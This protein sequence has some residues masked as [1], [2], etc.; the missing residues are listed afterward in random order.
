MSGHTFTFTTTVHLNYP[1][2][3]GKD[4]FLFFYYLY[5][6]QLTL[7]L[8][9][10][11]SVNF[12][13]HLHHLAALSSTWFAP[14]VEIFLYPSPLLLVQAG[15][16]KENWEAVQTVH[17]GGLNETELKIW[18]CCW[19]AGLKSLTVRRSACTI[20]CWTSAQRRPLVFIW[21]H[22]TST[23][24]CLTSMKKVLASWRFFITSKKK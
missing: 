1:L 21:R 12:V 24:K 8:F 15:T 13:L 6:S 19:S 14:N 10:R 23:G 11:N 5:M 22:M 16:V 2:N 4:V 9:K 7:S 17:G 20:S 18:T 3:L